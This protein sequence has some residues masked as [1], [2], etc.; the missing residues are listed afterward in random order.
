MLRAPN[1]ELVHY[2]HG[3]Y[4]SIFERNILIAAESGRVVGEETVDGIASA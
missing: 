3:G 1:G 2:R 4:A